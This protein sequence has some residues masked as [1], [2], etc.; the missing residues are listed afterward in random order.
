[1]HHAVCVASRCSVKPERHVVRARVRRRCAVPLL[2][3][4]S[5][6]IADVGL[7]CLKV[8]SRSNVPMKTKARPLN[9]VRRG[10]SAAPRVECDI[11]M[12]R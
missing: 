7:L 1:M 11:L 3:K 12:E 10:F 2:Q 4:G 9:Q 5:L 6:C 8:Q